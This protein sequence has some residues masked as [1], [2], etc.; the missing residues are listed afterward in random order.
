MAILQREDGTILASRSAIIRELAPLKVEIKS[1]C[2]TE[3]SQLRDLMV[4]EVLNLT[5]KYQVLQILKTQFEALRLKSGYQ[6]RDFM[7]LHPGSP[8]LYAVFTQSNRCHTH[9]EAEVLH[10]LAGECVFGL[11]GPDQ[12]QIQLLV[13]AEELI[14]IPAGIEHWFYLGPGLHLK[15]VRYYTRVEGWVPRYTGRELHRQV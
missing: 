7:V 1:L 2:L 14:E 3:S 9:T 5:E 11:I 12:S 10:V 4:Q 6:W 15:A 8:H 13:E